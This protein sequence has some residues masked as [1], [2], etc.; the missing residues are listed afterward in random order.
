M[1]L[2]LDFVILG[3]ALLLPGKGIADPPTWP[4]TWKE[5]ETF[6]DCPE[7]PE[8]VVIPSGSFRM[9]DLSGDGNQDETPPHDVVIRRPFALGKFEVT[10]DQWNVCLAAGG[11]NGYKP[12]DSGYGGKTHPVIHVDFHDAVAYTQWLSRTTGKDYRLPTE[13]EWEYAARAGTATKRWWG[14]IESHEFANFGQTGKCCAGFASGP[15]KWVNTSPV[16]SFPPNAFGVYDVLGNVWEWVSDCY[17]KDAYRTHSDYPEMV[18]KLTEKC[19]RVLRGGSWHVTPNFLRASQ[20]LERKPS[21]RYPYLGF[22][23]ARNQRGD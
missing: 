21:T 9:G 17:K 3:I 1:G 16:G 7:C 15:D 11:C 13:A 5:G 14:D 18:G 10:F 8:M 6:K 2:R 19:T 22:R 4:P 12:N 23:V 20:R